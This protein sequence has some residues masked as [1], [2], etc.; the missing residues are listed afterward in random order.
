MTVSRF[1]NSIS[2]WITQIKK[3]LQNDFAINQRCYVLN[4]SGYFFCSLVFPDIYIYMET[5]R[6]NKIKNFKNPNKQIRFADW[7]EHTLNKAPVQNFWFAVGNEYCFV[8]Y[9]SVSG[10]FLIYEY[11]AFIIRRL[12]QLAPTHPLFRARWGTDPR[13]SRDIRTV[14]NIHRGED[15][16]TALWI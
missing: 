6:I 4:I 1:Y 10:D 2:H 16:L 7:I 3:K 11:Y 9:N 8:V 14:H 15:C 13:A 5:I 12:Q